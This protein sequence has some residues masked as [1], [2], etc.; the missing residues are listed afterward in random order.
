MHHRTVFL[1]VLTL[2]AGP[3]AAQ[4]T[5]DSALVREVRA[6]EVA[7]AATMAARDSAAFAS[8]IAD[9][10]V[11]FAGTDPLRGRDAILRAW[12]PFFT[13][14]AAPFSWAPDLVEVL[15]T[16]DLAL[17]SGPVRDGQGAEIGRFNSIWRRSREGTWMVVFDRGS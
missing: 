12:G 15:G 14:A 11:F 9:E 2:T 5:V 3:L 6:R 16:G 7:F 8:F 17:T 4:T 13:E 10:A 1:A